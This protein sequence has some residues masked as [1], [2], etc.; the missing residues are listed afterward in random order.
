MGGDDEMTEEQAKRFIKI[1]YKWMFI[2]G[3]L[4]LSIII[5][6]WAIAIGGKI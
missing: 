2:F 6:L 1:I 5:S 4:L 3:I